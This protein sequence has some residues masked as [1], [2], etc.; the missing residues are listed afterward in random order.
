M[1]LLNL[2][3]TCHCGR[4]NTGNGQVHTRC[5]GC[6]GHLLMA[7]W[8][9]EQGVSITELEAHKVCE[10]CGQNFKGEHWKRKCIDCFKK[11]KES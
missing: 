7:D 8:K 5:T 10:D 2:I 1:K 4:I 6:N 3:N 9:N 11:S